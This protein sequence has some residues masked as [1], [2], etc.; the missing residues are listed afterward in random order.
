MDRRFEQQIEIA[1]NLATVDRCI[2]E[3]VLMRQW[4]NPLLG[5]ES[6]GEWSTKPGGRF[7]FTLHLP[8]LSPALDCEV[9]ERALGLVVWRFTGFFEG[10]DHWEG[11][12]HPFGVRLVNRFCFTIPN[13]LVRTGFDLFAS[14]LT[15][16]DMQAQ[17]HRLKVVAEQQQSRYPDSNGS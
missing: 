4:L 3:P 8:L 17:L 9:I 12:P 10:T 1:A 14:N 6:V 13:P 16:S 2:T 15:R 5:C 7:R 11:Q